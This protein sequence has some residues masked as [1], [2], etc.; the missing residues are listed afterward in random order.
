VIVASAGFFAPG[1]D[2]IVVPLR[3]LQVDQTR[4]RFFLRISSA[5]VKTVPLIPDQDYRWLADEGGSATND[6]IFKSL[7]PNPSPIPADAN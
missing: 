6:A 1:K 4:G 7:M 2:S 3:Y 5:E